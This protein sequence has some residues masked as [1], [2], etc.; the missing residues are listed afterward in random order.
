MIQLHLTFFE[1]PVEGTRSPLSLVRWSLC[2]I[3]TVWLAFAQPGMSHYW[4]IEP[5][6][7]AQIDAELYDQ[8]PDG[9]TLPGHIPHPPHEH[10][11]HPGNFVAG[12][13]L[14]N[15]FDATFYRALLSPAERLALLGQRLEMEV[16]AQTIVLAPPDQP[17]RPSR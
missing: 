13:T 17:P 8:L 9:E 11:S 5:A 3:S 16:I 7:H 10:P 14:A 1:H 12:L 2:L 6:V 15:P 4:L